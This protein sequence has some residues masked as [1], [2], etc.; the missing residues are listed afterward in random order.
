MEIY[1]NEKG[2]W[3]SDTI[4]TFQA[5]QIVKQFGVERLRGKLCQNGKPLVM[6]LMINDCIRMQEKNGIYKNYLIHTIASDGRM[7]LAELHEGNV[8]KRVDEKS[9]KY[10]NKTPGSLQ[11]CGSRLITVSPI[12]TLRIHK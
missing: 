2:K 11:T 9:L 4:S 6:R 12:G 10:T 3:V 1:E 7:A 5:Y 8:R